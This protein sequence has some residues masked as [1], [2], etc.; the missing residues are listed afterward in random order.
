M[1]HIAKHSSTMENKRYQR[2]LVSL[3]TECSNNSLVKDVQVPPDM[4][5]KPVFIIICCHMGCYMYKI[6]YNEHH[7]DSHSSFIL[8]SFIHSFIHTLCLYLFRLILIRRGHDRHVQHLNLLLYVITL[9]KRNMR[10]YYLFHI[11]TRTPEISS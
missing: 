2:F 11:K 3:V 4:M 7:G 1:I 6:C 10:L 5:S 9:S 8:R